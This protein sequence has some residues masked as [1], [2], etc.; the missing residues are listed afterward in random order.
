MLKIIS[1]YE[2]II[3]VKGN[4][5]KVISILYLSLINRSNIAPISWHCGTAS[6]TFHK[7]VLG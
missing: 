7:R 4:D 3:F 1:L 2:V 5:S 6:M